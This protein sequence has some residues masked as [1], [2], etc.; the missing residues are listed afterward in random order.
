MRLSQALADKLAHA[1]IHQWN[2]GLATLP[3][4]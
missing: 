4:M 1:C 3:C 2:A